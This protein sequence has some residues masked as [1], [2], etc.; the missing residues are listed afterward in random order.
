[1][2]IKTIKKNL[3]LWSKSGSSEIV[4]IKVWIKSNVFFGF[5]WRTKS[6]YAEILLVSFLFLAS[7]LQIFYQKQHFLFLFNVTF[8]WDASLKIIK[9]PLFVIVEV[10][11]LLTWGRYGMFNRMLLSSLLPVFTVLQNAPGFICRWTETL[12][13]E[14]TRAQASSNSC[15]ASWGAAE[16]HQLLVEI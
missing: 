4:W 13:L 7:H 15:C 12:I 1:M 6:N 14:Q 9:V 11:V 2:S 5:K 3:A 16:L 10:F 8:C